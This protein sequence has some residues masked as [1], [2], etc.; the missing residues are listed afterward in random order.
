MEGCARWFIT[1]VAIELTMIRK[2][3]GGTPN[4]RSCSEQ[5]QSSLEKE[6]HQGGLSKSACT[7]VPVWIQDFACA[8]SCF[9]KTICFLVLASFNIPRTG[10]QSNSG[11]NE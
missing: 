4:T 7:E 9:M 5:T 11:K 2:L 8:Y 10:C 6:E 3:T 1:A